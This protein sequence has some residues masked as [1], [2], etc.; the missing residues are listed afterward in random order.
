[1]TAEQVEHVYLAKMIGAH[2]LH[3]LT[4]NDPL[5]MFV[6]YSSA[7]AVV[8]NPGQ[9]AYVAANL[10]LDALAQY[11]HANGQPALAIG[12]GAIR[13]AGFLTRN[14]NV[15]DMLKSR[16]G[17]EATPAQDALDDLDRVLSA[18]ASR[19][20]VAR[21]DMQRL[22][23]IL[24]AAQTPRFA[25]IMPSKADAALA[26]EEDLGEL[27]S[28]M[29]KPERRGFVLERIMENTAKVLGTSADQI[30]ASKPLSDL[31]LDSLMAVELAGAIERDV[32]QPI[33]VMQLLGVPSLSG[34]VDLVAKILGIELDAALPSDAG[35]ADRED[36]KTE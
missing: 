6:L 32:G 20:S 27:L 26:G 24:P 36:L 29:P 12:W 35:S 31:G 15:V 34:V 10:Y 17:L 33:P 1:M 9:G 5:E 14:E 8:G 7:S 25:P 23:Q 11:R 19:V 18:G 2:N 13:D 16:T 30:D 4:Q 28:A 21:F 22:Q 3:N